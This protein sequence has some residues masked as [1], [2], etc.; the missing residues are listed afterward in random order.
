MKR[1][2][3]TLFWLMLVLSGLKIRAQVRP[4]IL[5]FSSQDYQSETQNWMLSQSENKFI[6]VANNGGLLELNGATW[7][8]Y[9][10]P[11]N[12]ILRSVKVID[13]KIYTGCYMEF[14]F[15]E[16][17]IYGRLKYTSL[18]PLLKEKMIEDEQFW[19]I[20][21]YGK[22]V[23]FQSLNRVY[24]LDTATNTFKIITGKSNI[25]KI[26]SFDNAIYLFESK[27][28]LFK[29][30]TKDVKLIVPI[31]KLNDDFI[32]KI[33]KFKDKPALVTRHHGF[34]SFD[35]KGNVKQ[36]FKYIFDTNISLYSAIQLKDKSFMLGSI[37]NG[38]YHISRKGNVLLHLNHDN[39]LSNNTILSL[40]EDIEGNVWAGLDNGIN[41]INLKTP[42][43]IYEDNTGQL[44]V[45]YASK[46]FK[47]KIYLGTNQGVFY[48]DL[49]DINNKRFKFI[50]NTN[51]QVWSLEVYNNQ[52]FCGH[53]EGTFIIDGMKA[54]LISKIMGT[55][56]I[57][58][59]KNHPNLLIQ[60]NYRGLSILEKNN[61]I[62][63]LRNKIKGFNNS[64]RYFE[65]AS[66][67]IIYVNHE[68]K[69]VFKL[70][71]NIDNFNHFEKVTKVKGTGPAKNSSL[72]KFR[73]NV[74]YASSEGV[75][76]LDND[77]GV[78]TKDST[79]SKL[80]E[81]EA[82]LSGKLIVDGNQRLWTF[83]K[84]N[85]NILSFN[86]FDS[87]GSVTHIS[88][89]ISLR[90]TMVG[91]ENLEEVSK[92]IYVIGTSDGY[93]KLN[94]SNFKNTNSDIS[95]N[96]VKVSNSNNSK[97]TLLPNRTSTKKLHFN[98]NNL[99]FTYSVPNYNKYTLVQYQYKLEGNQSYNHWSTLSTQSF[100]V[101]KNL[102]SS[103]YKFE[104]RAKIGNHLSGNIATYRF[105]IDKPWF[106]SN[107]AL[108]LY[109]LGLLIG[110]YFIHR[111]YKNYYDKIHRSVLEENK[112]HAHL[113]QLQ[114]EKEIVALKNNQLRNDIES[115]N[116]EL[117]T[118][119]MSLIK[120]NELLSNLKNELLKISYQTEVKD[121]IK[122]IDNNLNNNKD[123][124]FFQEAFNNVD[125]NFLK[126]I[127]KLHPDL[128]PNDLR[129]C[130]YL[131]L[132]LSSKEIAPLLNISVRSVEI[133]RYRLRKKMSLTHE[134]SLVNYILE[135]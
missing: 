134:K 92:N 17:D 28:G 89:P 50:S 12:T 57:K 51:G 122:I 16:R 117:A 109:I 110:G 47:N 132:N 30:T 21:S 88:M 103:D 73:K 61:G 69:G 13:N 85:L 27:V 35:E 115:K 118:S 64:S 66:D 54:K 49:N 53:N 9:P 60:G 26:F 119:T 77:K 111:S 33:V 99:S 24:L 114:N 82:Y 3:Y 42:V 98:Q 1:F 25:D 78:F 80:I 10:S 8:Q 2:F 90:K 107:L 93:L 105:T 133:K 126:K 39:G 108:S 32:I 29:L 102:T 74:L 19:N 59:I 38:I 79:Y 34:Y 6:Y 123:W 113:I 129:F 37:S 70:T 71:L 72:V 121:V 44:G 125:K 94:I 96:S 14:G 46:I 120:K 15:W 87:S 56:Q 23:V 128:T 7:M 22:W 63:H 48:R 112:R 20:I 101:F 5:T 52:L 45:V 67:S 100:T 11:N 83:T 68:Y 40:F 91:F 65:F 4:P 116:R 62:W 106:W 127:K 55:W 18:K 36:V 84:N 43:K 58:P 135:I 41:C 86:Q 97:V 81:T 76:L 75:F 31:S 124:A 131:R 95:I 104:V 130:A